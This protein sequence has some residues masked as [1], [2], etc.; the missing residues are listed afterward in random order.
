MSRRRCRIA[1]FV[2]LTLG[3]TLV[4]LATAVRAGTTPAPPV[5]V[6]SAEDELLSLIRQDAPYT[7][8]PAELFDGLG[9]DLPDGGA[10]VKQMADAAPGGAF[11]PKMLET[12]PAAK[13]GYRATWHVVRYP[14]YGL[15]WDITGLALKPVNPIR[16][17]PAVAYVNG[18][19]A[20]LYEFF[21][22]PKNEPGLAQYLAQRIPVLLVSIPGNYKPGGWTEPPSKRKPAYLIDRQLSD[23]ETRV[24][25]A[26]FT[27]M[28]IAEGLQRLMR[29]G[30]DVPA[31]IS[32]HSTSGELPFILKNR[33]KERLQDLHIG[34]GTGGP[35]WLRDTW[36]RT[37]ADDRNRS[38]RGYPPI[39][40]VRFRTAESYSHGY[41][42]PLN[43]MP[44]ATPLEV[45]ENW[46]KAELRRRPWFKQVIQDVEHQGSEEQRE[47]MDK[48]IRQLVAKSRLP[49][50]ADE[51]VLD[52]FST[53]KSTLSD[54]RKM[55]WTT[56]QLDDGHWDP[57][58]AKA[59]ELFVANRFRAK[60]P[61]IPI[62][63]VVYDVPMTH[64]GHI[65]RPRQLAGGTLAA[66]KWLYEP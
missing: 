14:Y 53:M 29:A 44:G 46:Y 36:E 15:E 31:L 64:Y 32:G 25:N 9:W 20:N 6:Q 47:A 4:W 58:P 7:K 41:L 66:V 8:V 52:L 43:P 23:G 56:A 57:D 16:G 17:L 28:L 51:V 24:R 19:A 37:A 5:P 50:R 55:I 13:L 11:D 1:G 33:L 26:I 30:T 39:S 60:N 34:W 45:A 61:G 49:V 48:T 40:E 21:L 22:T 63:V 2:S 3:V 62:R 59:R 18:G 65:E 54:Y 10:T 35:A 27:N 38:G 42:G 12:L